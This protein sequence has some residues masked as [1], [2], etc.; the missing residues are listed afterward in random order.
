M[1]NNIYANLN[2]AD[3]LSD[4]KEDV[5]KLLELK[6]IEEWSGRIVKEKE[7]TIRQAALVLAGQCIAILLHKLSQSESAHQTA[8][9]QTKGW[10]HTDTQ[11][12]GYT[13]REILTVGN[14]IVNLKLPYVVQKRE[15]KRRKNLLMLDS[16][17]C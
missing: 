17:L 12:H 14:V 1:E 7:E 6:N 11:R 13:K 2:F 10:W 3:S 15:K 8:I 9:N 16:V 4:F 5:T